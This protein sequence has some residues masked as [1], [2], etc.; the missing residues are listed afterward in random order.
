[1][2]T[3]M[4]GVLVFALAL[5]LEGH[6]GKISWLDN[7]SDKMDFKKMAKKYFEWLHGLFL[8]KP[9][10]QGIL[11][12]ASVLFVA[13]AV[14][15]VVVSVIGFFLGWLGYTFCILVIMF[16]C[17]S[18]SYIEK[19][20]GEYFVNIHER[21]F[22]ILFWFIIFNWYG[23]LCYWLLIAIEK[24]FGEISKEND[25]LQVAGRKLHSIAAWIPARITGL[26]YGLVGN[27]KSTFPC[28]MA[29]ITKP[30][31]ESSEVL[32]NC[33]KAALG[34]CEN[35]TEKGNYLAIRALVIWCLLGVPLI[36]LL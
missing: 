19:T 28:L 26:I 12:V 27:F 4:N 33:G 6:G 13:I 23:A 17:L 34:E 18:N 20:E 35:F 1:M 25:R 10:L 21:S 2:N 16:I 31:M 11:G 29:S 14:L 9:A 8:K 15:F 3:F 22:G 5:A 7:L 36:L 24:E 30:S 32:L